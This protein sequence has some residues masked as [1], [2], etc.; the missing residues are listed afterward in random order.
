MFVKFITLPNKKSLKICQPVSFM[1]WMFTLFYSLAANWGRGGGWLI[2][3]GEKFNLDF[4]PSHQLFSVPKCFLLLYQN[5]FRLSVWVSC[6]KYYLQW[7]Q[8]IS[9]RKH[10]F[11]TCHWNALSFACWMENQQAE[12]SSLHW[13]Y[14]LS[15]HAKNKTIKT[16]HKSESTFFLSGK[17]MWK[18]RVST[19]VSFSPEWNRGTKIGL[20]AFAKTGS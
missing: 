10:S 12:K 2:D 5:K 18:E 20:H 14:F 3:W 9:H 6:L 16:G 15:L 17:K 7:K 8:F 4:I 1:K 19:V 13:G 11:C